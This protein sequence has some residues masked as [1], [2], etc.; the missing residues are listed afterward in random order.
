[1]HNFPRR[2]RLELNTP[3]ELAIRAAI[4]AVEA[5]G[6]HPLLTQVVTDLSAA[7]E[8]LANYIDKHL[9]PTENVR[10]HSVDGLFFE[11]LPDGAVRI[12]KTDGAHDGARITFDQTLSPDSWASAVL[13]M[14]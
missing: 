2:A 7:R 9:Q 10:F 8:E 12:V 3:A 13:A 11:Q 6:A 5:A 1:M 4:D 14:S